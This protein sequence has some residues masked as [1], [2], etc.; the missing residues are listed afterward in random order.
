MQDRRLR[1]GLTRQVRA[2]EEEGIFSDR[3]MVANGLGASTFHGNLRAFHTMPPSTSGEHT[4]PFQ[5]S[6]ILW[7]GERRVVVVAD[8]DMYAPPEKDTL[9]VFWGNQRSWIFVSDLLDAAHD[10]YVRLR[11]DGMP[12]PDARAAALLLEPG[13]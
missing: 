5:N 11:R 10:V 3:S 4:R 12:P 6:V 8:T 2:W 9:V 7:I 13:A 1:E